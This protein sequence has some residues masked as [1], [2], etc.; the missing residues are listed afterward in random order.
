MPAAKSRSKSPARS[1]VSKAKKVESI[2]SLSKDN[3]KADSKRIAA[4][5]ELF[6]EIDEDGNGQID[7][8][9]LQEGMLKLAGSGRKLS[10]AKVKQMMRSA[11][12]DKNGTIS[13]DEFVTLVDEIYDLMDRGAKLSPTESSWSSLLNNFADVVPDSISVVDSILESLHD[14]VKEATPA[15]RIDDLVIRHASIGT[16][17]MAFIFGNFLVGLCMVAYFGVFFLV[18][19][20]LIGASVDL[21]QSF[22]RGEIVGNLPDGA[23]QIAL[24][25]FGLAI[26]YPWVFA[27]QLAMQGQNPYHYIFGLQ[28]VDK[29]TFAHIGFLK[30]WF[31]EFIRIAFRVPVFLFIPAL[32]DIIMAFASSEGGSLVDY[33]LGT[34]V[35]VKDFKVV[36]K[37]KQE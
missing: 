21:E 24:P 26:I 30:L 11:D 2:E 27:I 29:K 8:F 36:K 37:T 14:S 4:A 7:A 31:R 5:L 13:F 35:I 12:I 19:L 25:I 6:H 17:I 33:I 15:K 20:F 18:S 23:F 22:R 28:V 16:R 34:C 9:E 10:T 32:V 1:S 3:R